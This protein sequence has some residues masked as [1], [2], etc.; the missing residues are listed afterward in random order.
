MAES[1]QNLTSAL[2]TNIG[3]KMPKSSSEAFKKQAELAPE[4][5]KAGAELKRA[6]MEFETGVLGSK[7][8]AAEKFATD[9][10]TKIED[11]RDKELL[12]PRPEFHP[13]KENAE[14][15]GSLFSMVATF[16]LMLGN[17]G[18]LA[19]QNAMG[20]MSG[21]LKGWQEGRQD[22]YEKELKEYEKNYQR[23][24][25]MRE[26][27][28]K[29]LEDYY[30]LATSDREAAQLK[31]E[32]IARKAGTN[33]VI[34]NYARKG[35]INAIVDLYEKS[36]NFLQKEEELRIRRSESQRAAQASYQYFEKDGKVFA[37]N[38][39]NP[40]DVREVDP[41][42]AGAGKLGA[43]PPGL[44]KKGETT[45]QAIGQAIGRPID[46]DTAQKI[47]ST[48]DFTGKLQDLKEKSKKLGGVSG[49]AIQFSDKINQ[50]LVSRV[51]KDGNISMNDVKEASQALDNDKSFLKLSDNS[52]IMA[53]AELDTI[54]SY[55]Q[56]KYGNRAPV[57]E[58][59]AASSAISR[60]SA[61]EKAFNDIMNNEL[62]SALKR[63]SA[64]GIKPEE[65]KAAAEFLNKSNVGYK[66]LFDEEQPAASTNTKEPKEGDTGK[67][68]SGKSII[69]RDGNWHYVD[70]K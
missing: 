34:G 61:S 36:G 67:S 66:E 17:S 38:T 13:T 59:R 50:F 20:A 53:K 52:K 7:A 23:I 18:K 28:R 9:V 58:F 16:G 41:R 3:F 4:Q 6:E 19:A 32:M 1:N 15:L 26:D 12:L 68:K 11:T 47:G 21:M 70:E 51:D 8:E 35:E 37:I 29:D 25:D 2:N 24:K 40:A 22:L 64:T 42:L 48:W 27:L 30:K 56:Q 43:K 60:K 49:V 44:P 57:A 31:L 33:S 63:L 14:S 10:R 39:K 46:V 62:E 5:A 69:F 45:A 65:Y 55:L 54:M